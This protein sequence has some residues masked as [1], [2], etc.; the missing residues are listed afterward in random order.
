MEATGPPGDGAL[1]SRMNV[2]GCAM[3]VVC[4]SSFLATVT[5]GV[6]LPQVDV[7]GHGIFIHPLTM[8]FDLSGLAAA[9]GDVHKSGVVKY[10]DK[11][12]TIRQVANKEILESFG[13]GQVMASKR[14]RDYARIVDH[15]V[16]EEAIFGFAK[17]AV[18]DGPDTDS[19]AYRRLLLPISTCAA[20][21]DCIVPKQRIHNPAGDY[22]NDVVGVSVLIS[23][24]RDAEHDGSLSDVQMPVTIAVGIWCLVLLCTW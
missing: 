5:C 2:W 3:C 23:R 8:H 15:P 11:S 14:K 17:R 4:C 20:R 18:A 13:V 10:W 12:V 6:F 7:F 1:V 19:A 16:M 9:W 24:G 22:A 21:E